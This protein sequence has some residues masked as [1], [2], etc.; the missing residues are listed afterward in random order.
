MGDTD[1]VEVRKSRGSGE[2]MCRETRSEDGLTHWL[3]AMAKGELVT[4]VTSA[5]AIESPPRTVLLLHTH[6]LPP[7]SR[8][9]FP[10]RKHSSSMAKG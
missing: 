4:Q 5:T 9:S 8:L 2:G 7:A 3:R 1:P 10:V 6:F